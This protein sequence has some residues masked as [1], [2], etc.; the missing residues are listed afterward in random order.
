MYGCLVG[1]EDGL[2][3]WA[4]VLGPIGAKMPLIDGGELQRPY[5][6]SVIRGDLLPVLQAGLPARQGPRSSGLHRHPR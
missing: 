5:S 4:H 6:S 1:R 2:H 3:G